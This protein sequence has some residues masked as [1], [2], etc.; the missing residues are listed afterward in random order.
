[1]P[2][3]RF[4]KK[5]DQDSLSPSP[6][7]SDTASSHDHNSFSIASPSRFL[8]QWDL[9]TP[10]AQGT[11]PILSPST[12]SD[13]INRLSS[14][15]N[16]FGQFVST[17]GL[18]RSV[19]P[20]PSYHHGSSGDKRAV[21]RSTHTRGTKGGGETSGND[22]AFGTQPLKDT[23]AIDRTPAGVKVQK[24]NPFL[25]S[26]V[27]G[28]ERG[29]A[30]Q[31]FVHSMMNLHKSH[32]S[33]HYV[34]MM[35]STSVR[36]H[37]GVLGGAMSSEVGND[38]PP[39][40]KSNAIMLPI[41]HFLRALRSVTMDPVLVLCDRSTELVALKLEIDQIDAGLLKKVHFYQGLARNPDHQMMTSLE[42]AKAIVIMR[43]PISAEQME[44]STLEQ[45][46]PS[47]VGAGKIHLHH[48]HRQFVQLRLILPP[49]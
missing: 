34:L 1:V 5:K 6:S 23:T 42:H 18:S 3:N 22:D 38:A 44:E 36:G 47:K 30:G 31:R 19:T 7:D 28:A 45:V 13:R 26:A 40:L 32:L 33:N 21:P 43:P 46:I 29:S 27:V 49:C 48:S 11:A 16:L 15:S 17:E 41:I 2:S 35:T 20:S 4:G 39:D 12:I 14:D 10:G 8:S 24:L 25:A 9:G 37:R